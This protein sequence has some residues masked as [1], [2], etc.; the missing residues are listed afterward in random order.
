MSASDPLDLDRVMTEIR[1]EVRARR[2]AGDFPPSLER[3]LDL[4]FDRF[5][6]KE[7]LDSDFTEAI[8]A[9][10]R[11]AYINVAVPTDSQKAGVGEVKR[12]LRKAMGW[13][14][15]YL[16]QQMTAFGTASIRA[17]RAL[18]ERQAVLEEQV[19]LWRPREDDGRDRST[20]ALDVSAW[21]GMAVEHMKDAPGRVMHAECG[22][23][24]LVRLLTDAG[25][26]AYGVDPRGPLV[27]RAVADGLDAFP[28][29]PFIHIDAVA[30]AGLGG[31]VLSGWPDRAT[32]G[33]K[34]A[35]VEKLAEKLAPGG[36]IA[37]V[38]AD[39]EQWARRVS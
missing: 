19:A 21:A 6:P 25:V 29:D 1:E 39:P 34:W 13:Y 12:V 9:A 37:L 33:R 26:D 31:I 36:R 38:A 27:D 30:A 8:Q 11:A 18:G 3:D 28:D 16:A 4:V 14:L 23:G 22:T 5:V 17:L 24:Q 15:D 20:E 32:L 2:A 35:M 10:D 7:P